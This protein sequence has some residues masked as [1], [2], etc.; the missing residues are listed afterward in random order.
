MARKIGDFI[1]AETGGSRPLNQF[2]VLARE[3]APHDQAWIV[4]TFG[5]WRTAAGL[6]ALNANTDVQ[7][8]AESCDKALQAFEHSDLSQ[9][10][11]AMLAAWTLRAAA[12]L[13]NADAKG[14]MVELNLL[15]PV[16]AKATFD[17]NIFPP[18]FIAQLKQKR[19]ELGTK[20][21]LGLEVVAKPAPAR[22]F[23]DGGFRGVTPLELAGLAPGEHL[24]VVRV[25]DSAGNTGVAKV[26]LN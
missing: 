16:G 10:F 4:T 7:K 14:A 26:L 3:E 1:L 25:A 20:S 13:A 8:A 18:D 5:D 9:S 6:A 17:P 21:N 24:L 22:V 11:D 23:L 19:E 2:R 15:L 12:L